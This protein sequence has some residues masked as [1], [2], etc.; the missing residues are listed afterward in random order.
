MKRKYSFPSNVHMNF[1]D[2]LSEAKALESKQ[3][4]IEA[5]NK[6]REAGNLSLS[7]R[8]SAECFDKQREM[9][10]KQFSGAE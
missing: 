7:R 2:V 1:D 9:L 3:D 5:A 10:A 6:Y 8:R 4:W